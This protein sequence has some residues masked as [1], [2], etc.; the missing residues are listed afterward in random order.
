[1]RKIL[2][3]FSL[4][5]SGIIHSQG[6]VILGGGSTQQEISLAGNI[7]SISGGGSVDLSYLLDNTDNQTVT[8]LSLSGDILSITLSG[9]NT[10]TV[11][12]STISGSIDAVDITLEDS[13][14]YFPT[15]NVEAGMQYLAA[16]VDAVPTLINSDD[17]TGATT[18]NVNSAAATQNYVD[19]TVS[20]AALMG[21]V[22]FTATRMGL[23]TD[24][25]GVI[26]GNNASNITY[27]V[28]NNSTV[29]HPVGTIL[30]FEQIGTGDIIMDYE[31]GVTGEAMKTFGVGFTLSIR[32]TDTN[33]WKVQN[34][35]PAYVTQT[36]YDAL[37][38]AIKNN[39][40]MQFN[41]VP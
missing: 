16:A 10:K 5:L 1:M 29:A 6:V 11:D 34:A 12:L 36:E 18:S 2:I 39:P 9:G 17:F 40:K 4:L 13:G 23:L 15:D 26:E 25:N 33:T 20:N 30:Y 14:A 38:T 27:T 24:A 7:L 32:K 21:A 22:S 8:D 3:I 37:S 19:N 31:S 35:S 28:P 41:I